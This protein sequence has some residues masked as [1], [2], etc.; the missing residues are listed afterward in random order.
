M[1]CSRP[2]ARARPPARQTAAYAII[3]DLDP[4]NLSFYLGIT[5]ISTGLG[6]MVTPP[7]RA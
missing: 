7:T 3:A 1:R 4:E 6:Y 5:E 2:P